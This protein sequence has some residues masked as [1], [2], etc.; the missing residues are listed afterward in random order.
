MQKSKSVNPDPMIRLRTVGSWKNDTIELPLP[1][2]VRLSC[3][4]G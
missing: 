3:G 1:N 4:A 2:E